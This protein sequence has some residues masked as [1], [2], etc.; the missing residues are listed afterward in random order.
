[1]RETVD[2]LIILLYPTP[3]KDYIGLWELTVTL[4]TSAKTLRADT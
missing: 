4:N 2:V 1:M 3:T